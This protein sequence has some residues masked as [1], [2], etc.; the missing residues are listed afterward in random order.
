M[1]TL[2]QL[3][4]ELTQLL[5]DRLALALALLLPLFQLT[6]MGSSLSLII[7]DLPIV[8]QDFDGSPASRELIDAFRASLTFRIVPLPPDRVRPKRAQKKERS[9][10]P[11]KPALPLR[12][13]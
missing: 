13:Y 2:A 1:R 12:S 3:R 8:V 9:H 6:L 11:R 4:K 10:Q 5:R 7:Q